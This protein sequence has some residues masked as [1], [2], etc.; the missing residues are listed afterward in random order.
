[1]SLLLIPDTNIKP[2]DLYLMFHDG[3]L[4]DSSKHR[5]FGYDVWAYLPAVNIGRMQT[6]ILIRKFLKKMIADYPGGIS[7]KSGKFFISGDLSD[8]HKT[9]NEIGTDYDTRI[10]AWQAM[11]DLPK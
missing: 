1:M 2:R 8:F 9:H 11:V 7:G 4:E 3:I 6:I 5:G 10:R